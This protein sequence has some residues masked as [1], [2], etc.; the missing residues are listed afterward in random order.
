MNKQKR[1][2]ES[3]NSEGIRSQSRVPRGGRPEGVRRV[4]IVTSKRAPL[5]WTDRFVSLNIRN[6]HEMEK[7]EFTGIWYE[8]ATQEEKMQ[9]SPFAFNQLYWSDAY[10]LSKYIPANYRFIYLDSGMHVFE[11]TDWTELAEP[12]GSPAIALRPRI[13]EPQAP[14]TTS[15]Q[16]KN[17]SKNESKG[18]L[19]VKE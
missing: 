17:V 11:R 13:P 10:L 16:S 9:T 14:S 12:A 4:E 1:V 8:Q 15:H 3:K 7:S 18:A 6:L 5:A 2:E 19:E